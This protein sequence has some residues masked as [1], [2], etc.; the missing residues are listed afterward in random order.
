LVDFVLLALI[1]GWLFILLK[2]LPK[3]NA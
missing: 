2:R 1:N 3:M